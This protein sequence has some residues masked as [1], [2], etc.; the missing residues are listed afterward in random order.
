MTLRHFVRSVR[1]R[2]ALTASAVVFGT[3]AVAIGAVYLV[4]RSYLQSETITRYRVEGEVMRVGGRVFVV[5]RQVTP[6]QV[7]SVEAVYR[8]LILNRVTLMV[9]VS[10]GVLFVV[11]VVMGWMSAGRTLRP[12]GEMTRVANDIQAR[13]LS[14]RIEVRVPDD[15]L[16]QLASTFNAMLDRLQRAF[17]QQKVFL[18]QTSHDLRTP[19]AVM[20]SNLEVTL[21]DPQANVEDWRSTAAVVVK[22]GERMS[23]M[24]DSL[25]TSA[26]FEAGASESTEVDLVLLASELAEEARARIEVEPYEGSGS[27]VVHG[28]R[29][30]LERAVGNLIEN[31]IDAAGGPLA[32]VAGREGEWGYVAVADRGPGFDPDF[33]RASPG[34]GLAIVKR[35]AEAHGGLV[36]MVPRVGGGT[37]VVLFIPPVDVVPQ[38]P[39]VSVRL[40]DL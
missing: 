25:L 24:I 16:G 21:D 19:L 11:S 12:L 29:P 31:A 23:E 36:E 34:L 30:A 14:R 22:A 7:Q 5:P 26:R 1:F 15:E 17:D 40:G 33:L 39:P 18:A 10:L 35:V 8:Q 3:G 20:R 32:V 28:N 9:L 6:E 27:V 2:L 38:M 37:V 13:D 4:L